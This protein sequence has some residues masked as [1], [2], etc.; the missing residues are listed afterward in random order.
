[1]PKNEPDVEDPLEMVGMLVPGD[2]RKMTECF[3]EEYMM[4]GYSDD[5]LLRLFRDPFYLGVNRIFQQ[6]GEQFVIDVIGQVRGGGL[7]S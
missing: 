2:D 7:S 5:E 6:Y 4:M 3:V 1:M